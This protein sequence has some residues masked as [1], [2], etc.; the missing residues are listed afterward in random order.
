MAGSWAEE[1]EWRKGYLN[2]AYS[3]PVGV[4]KSFVADATD[5]SI[6]DE[7]VSDV[8]G[9]LTG[10]DVEFDGTTPP[11]AL[12]VVIKTI[13]G[14]TVVT[15]TSL[16]ASGRVPVSPPVDLA[17]G[18]IISCSTNTTNSAEGNVVCLFR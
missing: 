18:Y 16:T 15:G 14:I 2:N 4:V 10:I 9:L 5:G 1:V 11:N 7:T 6:P 3:R 12:V 8:S 13:G 17:G